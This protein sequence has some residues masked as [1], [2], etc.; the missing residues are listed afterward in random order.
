MREDW[1]GGRWVEG[2]GGVVG[3]K[4]EDEGGDRRVE[5]GEETAE[6]GSDVGDGGREGSEGESTL[7]H[8]GWDRA[9]CSAQE[10]QGELVETTADTP[11]E[12]TA[13]G[14][15]TG[16]GIVSARVPV[17]SQKSLCLG[18][19]VEMRWRHHADMGTENPRGPRILCEF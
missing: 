9:S 14:M 12:E 2:E 11:A 3:W 1:E 18:H 6:V 17:L 4:D 16:D 13:Y 15:P 8:C 5:E 10:A 19:V 7:S